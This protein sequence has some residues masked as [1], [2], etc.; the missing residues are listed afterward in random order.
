M[1][2]EKKTVTVYAPDGTQVKVS[3]DRAEELKTRG[4]GTS[5]PASK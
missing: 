4:Y 3:E 1:A 5:K 2:E